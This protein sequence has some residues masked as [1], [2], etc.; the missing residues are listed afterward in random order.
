MHDCAAQRIAAPIG[1]ALRSGTTQ[2]PFVDRW[3]R[4]LCLDSKISSFMAERRRLAGFSGCANIKNGSE[5]LAVGAN[6][7]LGLS[8][9]SP[10]K[11]HVP[12]RRSS[13]ETSRLTAVPYAST[14]L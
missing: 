10:P 1:K 4:F 6:L 7:R 11:I 13:G 3:R 8:D 2:I 14:F 5:E 12:L 9:I